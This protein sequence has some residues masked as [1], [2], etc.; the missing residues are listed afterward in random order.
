M[1]KQASGRNVAQESVRDLLSKDAWDDW[2]RATWDIATAGTKPE[3]SNCP[4]CHVKVKLERV[5]LMARVNAAEKL[6]SMGYGKPKDDDERTRGFV[7]NR[8]IVNP[9][10]SDAATQ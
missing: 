5:D 6:Q 1:A 8:T 10:G 9:G 2:A 3:Y 4:K 7:L